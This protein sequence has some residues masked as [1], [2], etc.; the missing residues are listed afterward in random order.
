MSPSGVL[1]ISL[2]TPWF[3]HTLEWI[4]CG[5][6]LINADSFEGTGIYSLMAFDTLC[7][8]KNKR[9]C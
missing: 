9:K 5:N 3:F 1:T 7:L 2:F 6:D 8:Y 4:L